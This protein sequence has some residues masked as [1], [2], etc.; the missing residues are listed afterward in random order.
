MKQIKTLK[1]VKI[2]L[3]SLSH[4]TITTTEKFINE[5]MVNT[6][7]CELIFSNIIANKLL[8]CKSFTEL[9]F[10]SQVQIFKCVV[11]SIKQYSIKLVTQMK[12]LENVQDG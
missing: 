2:Y 10:V 4:K 12:D 11:N 6:D 9:P 8:G 5:C 7:Y 1:R 3:T